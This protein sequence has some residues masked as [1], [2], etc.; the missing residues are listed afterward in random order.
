MAI[1]KKRILGTILTVL[2]FVTMGKNK[3][4]KYRE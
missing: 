2:L 3:I 4:V 1:D